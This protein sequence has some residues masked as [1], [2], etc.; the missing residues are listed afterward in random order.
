MYFVDYLHTY[1]SMY[2]FA[3]TWLNGMLWARGQMW[4]K[5]YHDSTYNTGRKSNKI[6]IHYDNMHDLKLSKLK[7]FKLSLR[8]ALLLHM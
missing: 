6:N 3:K 5:E 8:N 1:T 7:N 2:I 4:Q